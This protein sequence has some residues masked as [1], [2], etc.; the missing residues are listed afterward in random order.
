ML[1]IRGA[2]PTRVV[3]PSREMLDI[4]IA[5]SGEVYGYR[6]DEKMPPAVRAGVTPSK[7][8]DKHVGE[9]NTFDIVF[10]APRFHDDGSGVTGSAASRSNSPALPPPVP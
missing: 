6:M 7:N 8:A 5:G 2:C 9:W 4:G 10:R 1:R 3:A